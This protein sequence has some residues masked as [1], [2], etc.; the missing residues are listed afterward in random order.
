VRVDV[1]G[2][3][4]ARDETPD[5]SLSVKTSADVTLS[6]TWQTSLSASYLTGTKS[7]GDPYN[8]LLF[9]LFVAARF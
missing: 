3:Y 7:D 6:K 8:S 1:D 2:S 5:I 9:E 4:A